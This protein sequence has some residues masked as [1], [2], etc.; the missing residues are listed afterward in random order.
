MQQVVKFDQ[1]NQDDKRAKIKQKQKF[2]C[3]QYRYWFQRSESGKSG[4]QRSNPFPS[5]ESSLSSFPA[6]PKQLFSLFL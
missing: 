3:I 2:P 4:R 6:L 1:D 5:I